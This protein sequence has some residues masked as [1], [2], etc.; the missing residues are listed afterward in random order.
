LVINLSRFI[1][2]PSLDRIFI[3]NT[4]IFASFT[5][6]I[7]LVAEHYIV[8]D[9]EAFSGEEEL[10]ALVKEKIFIFFAL[11]SL[12]NFLIFLKLARGL[13]REIVKIDRYLQRVGNKK[14]DR[15]FVLSFSTE[16]ILIGEKIEDV[17]E[18]LHKLNKKK[19]KYNAQLKIANYQQEKLLGAISHELK[20]PMS[21]II[22]YAQ[23]LRD[24]LGKDGISEIYL[25]FLDKIIN[26]GKRSDELLNRLR[27]AVQLENNKFQLKYSVFDIASLIDKS[28]S[29]LKRDWQKREIDKRY[30]KYEVYADKTL[31]ELVIINLVE[32]AFKYSDGKLIISI[33]NNHIKIQ[34]F[35]VGIDKNDLSNV[36]KRFYRADIRS[37]QQ[38]MG[39]GLAIVSYILRLHNLDLKIE[40]EVGK[41]STFSINLTPIS[42]QELPKDI[43]VIG[44]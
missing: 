19:R 17:I 18:K 43:E 25:K 9:I 26:N 2:K 33:E 34:D 44:N 27:L 22:G 1:N 32:N 15:K 14:S 13:K 30:D 35:G 16:F 42:N 29:N 3:V 38:S 39:L 23:I 36:T 11:L 41:G 8:Q 40:S 28:I 21:S 5:L 12:I 7:Y 4:A 20:N 6:I 10:K 24:E 31:M 37:H